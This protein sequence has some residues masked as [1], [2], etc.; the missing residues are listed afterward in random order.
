MQRRAITRYYYLYAI[1]NPKQKDGL[2]KVGYSCDPDRRLGQLKSYSK[3]I[4]VIY[5]VNM[6]TKEAAVKIEK[7]FHILYDEQ[8]EKDEWFRIP[9]DNLVEALKR[10]VRHYAALILGDER[11][12]L[13][14]P[15]ID[16]RLGP[17]SPVEEFVFSSDFHSKS[18]ILSKR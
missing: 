2:F 16:S 4:E 3:N 13:H 14:F 11:Q 7:I 6:K 18:Q 5:I 1:G 12:H 8:R 15:I 17:I 10:S 9:F